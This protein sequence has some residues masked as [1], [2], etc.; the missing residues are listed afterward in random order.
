M[1]VFIARLKT[2]L[3]RRLPHRRYDVVCRIR[4]NRDIAATDDE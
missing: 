4:R 2:C 3:E 1:Y